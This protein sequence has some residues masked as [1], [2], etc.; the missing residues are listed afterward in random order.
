MEYA[1]VSIG[2]RSYI[3]PVHGVAFSK[4]PVAAAAQGAGGESV[5]TQLNDVM[6]TEYHLFA[7]EAHIVA[8]EDGKK[9]AAPPAESATPAADSVDHGK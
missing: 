7:T 3:C 5:E 1:T 6:F 4:V 8:D 2:D 9:G